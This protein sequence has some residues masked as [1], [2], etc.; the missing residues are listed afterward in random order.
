M[1]QPRTTTAEPTGYVAQ[2]VRSVLL[3]IADMSVKMLSDWC[4]LVALA[5]LLVGLQVAA[6]RQQEARQFRTDK[7]LDR[8]EDKIDRDL[9]EVRTELRQLGEQVATIEGLLRSDEV[10]AP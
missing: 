6:D 4:R 9:G 5:A 1:E 10:P 3:E 7:R 2:A 8:I